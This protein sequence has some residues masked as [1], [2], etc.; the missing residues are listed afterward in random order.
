[1]DKRRIL[2]AIDKILGDL[3]FVRDKTQFVIDDM[4]MLK[5]HIDEKDWVLTTPRKKKQANV[6]QSK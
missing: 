2:N 1:M 6:E 3:K 4:G 5:K